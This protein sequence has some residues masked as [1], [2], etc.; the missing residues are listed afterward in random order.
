MHNKQSA[1]DNFKPSNETPA[2]DSDDADGNDV[3]TKTAQA[4][5]VQNTL[6]TYGFENQDMVAEG[7]TIVGG[8]TWSISYS[9]T[10]TPHDGSWSLRLLSSY[11]EYQSIYLISPLIDSG[12]ED[13]NVEFYYQMRVGSNHQPSIQVGYSTTT[14][15]IDAFSWADAITKPTSGSTWY[16][17]ELEVPAATKYAVIKVSV[18][19]GKG[20]FRFDDISF[21]KSGY[22][23][24]T[25]MT[26]N[27]ITD[28]SATVSWNAPEPTNR[29]LTGYAYQYKKAE[30]TSWSAEF[31]TTG[32]TATINDLEANTNYDIRVKA[33]YEDGESLQ[34]AT[35]TVLTDCSGSMSLPFLEN[36]SNGMGC[37][38][39]VDG[40]VSTVSGFFQFF[41]TDYDQHLISPQLDCHSEV[42]ISFNYNANY[43]SDDALTFQ[44]GYSTT[45]PHLSDFTWEPTINDT[46]GGVKK[47]ENTFPA[48]IK[49]VAIKKMGD[50]NG[51][52]IDDFSVIAV[53]ALPPTN[54]TVSNVSCHG[55]TLTWT[56]PVTDKTVT[57]YSY[58]LEK[59]V[60][61]WGLDTEAPPSTT[62]VT[63]YNLAADT[64]Y[65]F[66]VMALYGEEKSV[67]TSLHFVTAAE[68]PQYQDFENGMGRWIQVD[69]NGGIIDD[70]AY[71]GSSCF[72]F[73]RKTDNTPQYLISPLFEGS[74]PLLLS[75]YYMSTTSGH[76]E[77]FQVGYSTTTSDIS[78][79]SWGN[80]VD[81]TTS[82]WTRYEV[83]CPVGTKFI[84]IKYASNHNNSWKMY[85]DDISILEYSPYAKPTTVNFPDLSE[86]EVTVTWNVPDA[87]AT[88]YAYQYKKLSENTWSAET[89]TKTTSVTLNNLTPNTDYFFRVKALYGSNASNYNTFSFLTEAP[90]VSI[91]YFDG[92]ENGMGGWRMY[93]NG[94]DTGIKR[95]GSAHSGNYYFN[96]L[97]ATANQNQQ[98]VSPQLPGG[99]PIKVSFYYKN[100]ESQSRFIVGYAS[101]KSVDVTWE[102]H[103]VTTDSGEWTLYQTVIPAD[104]HYF[105]ILTPPNSGWLY[106][107]DFSFTLD[108]SDLFLADDADNTSNIDATNGNEANVTLN[109]RT[110]YKDG[111]WNTLCL[112]FDVTLEGSPLEGASVKELDSAASNVTDG[113]LNLVFKDATAIEAGKPYIVKW[114]PPTPDLTISTSDEWKAF[115][116]SVANGT[117]YEGQTVQLGADIS[118]T[119]MAGADGKLFKGNLDGKGHTITANINGGGEGTALFYQIEDATIQNLKVRGSITTNYHRPATFAALV[120]GVSNIKN[121]WSAVNLS[122]TRKNDWV[123]CGAIIAR[124]NSDATVNITDCAFTGTVTFDDTA[125]EGGSMVGWTPQNSTA[126]L[127][128]CLYAPSALTLNKADSRDLT[129][130]F[131]S[132]WVRGNLTDCYYNHVAAASTVLKKEGTDASG[133]SNADLLSALGSNWK[134]S[135]EDVVPKM[136][137]SNGESI[138]NPVFTGVTI[139]N[140]SNNTWNTDQSVGFVGSYDPIRGTWADSSLLLDSD[141][142]LH[143]AANG[144]TQGALRAFVRIDNTK[145][146]T[147]PAAYTIDFGNGETAKGVL[148]IIDGDAN[149]D[150]KVTITDAVGIVNYILGNPSAFFNTEAAD[151][152]HD[153]K[154]TITDAVAVVNIILNSKE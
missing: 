3:D 29:I 131:V 60:N 136:N 34:Y 132:G 92:F 105:V 152:N 57:G 149:G 38:R 80:V 40:H 75:F 151:V 87:S 125:Y 100:H 22:L 47:Y 7:W 12:G 129:Y 5:D 10:T 16:F 24:P 148:R 108:T 74:Y 143:F 115:A 82:S 150:G 96:F 41:E 59:H 119:A 121:C 98:L 111:L 124:V 110:L 130:A 14:K 69:G 9:N 83:I 11:P 154:I 104:A 46:P 94:L 19:N 137:A 134:M 36:F 126:N 91:P 123:D 95:T 102:D 25:G 20:P 106:L 93:G 141:N 81:A 117:T 142:T 85:L 71:T 79:F 135:G 31:S 42:I 86:T 116:T 30:E 35:M 146:A 37:W 63:S 65:E 70:T 28:Q 113:T 15:E 48:D 44:V 62:S 76:P 56:P 89:T 145:V 72:C 68:L 120:S 140:T 90:M 138:K 53:G 88:G 26:L 99:T 139:D 84:V 101:S 67:Y 73:W 1:Y 127:T 109:G 118:V 61:P 43:I 128:R 112:P 27:D 52:T 39:V 66:R 114:A 18:T 13:F 153:G 107:D 55:A 78:A 54:P 6:Y 4:D 8:D 144:E 122:S 45:G 133:M 23:P 2:A 64:D 97:T 21:V 32:T 33:I 77:S 58:Q 51:L 49:Y 50:G 17:Y 147:M 103:W